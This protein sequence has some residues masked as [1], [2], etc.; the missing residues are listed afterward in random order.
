MLK[1]KNLSK[2]RGKYPCPPELTK[3]I[4]QYN[5]STSESLQ[6][7]DAFAQSE[8]MLERYRRETGDEYAT[9]DPVDVFEQIYNVLSEELQEYFRSQVER[10]FEYPPGFVPMSD[11]AQLYRIKRLE[12]LEANRLMKEFIEQR[13][14]AGRER[15]V[16]DLSVNLGIDYF[17]TSIRFETDDDGQ[18]RIAGLLGLIGT[19]D[20]RMLRLCVIENCGRAFWATRKNSVTCSTKC[21]AKH[22]N[23]PS[24]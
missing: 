3:L 18:R 12:I 16:E 19:F 9:I 24:R 5:F 10:E 7:I 8:E 13:Q 17:T 21:Y 4:D 6:D 20:D 1:T 22:R 2:P 11:M 23:Q 14:N 15:N